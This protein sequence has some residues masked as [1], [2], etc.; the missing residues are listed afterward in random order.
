[1]G[2]HEISSDEGHWSKLPGIIKDWITD[3]DREIVVAISPQESLLGFGTC[4]SYMLGGAYRPRK[5]LHV[6]A[7]YVAPDHRN[8][9]LGKS[10]MESMLQWGKEQECE[11][12][13]LNVHIDN[14]A[15][16]LYEKRGFKKLQ[17]QMSKKLD[18]Q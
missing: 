18:R 14:P 11:A 4:K 17:V 3:K 5:T 12:C 6:G 2:G 1:M 15:I 7:L 9:G 13:E 10:L 16:R 8:K